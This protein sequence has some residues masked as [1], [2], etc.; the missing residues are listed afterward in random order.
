MFGQGFD[1]P[2]LHGNQYQKESKA[3]KSLI[4][5]LFYFTGFVKLLQFTQKTSE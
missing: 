5:G 4:Y 3:R 1:S 2:Q